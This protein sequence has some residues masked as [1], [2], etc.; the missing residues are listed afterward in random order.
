MFGGPELTFGDA[1]PLIYFDIG[2]TLNVRALKQAASSSCGFIFQENWSK[3]KCWK[4]S[5]RS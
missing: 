3:R 5:L 2:L 4:A 1:P